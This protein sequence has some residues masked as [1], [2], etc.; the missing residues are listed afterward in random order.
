MSDIK[1]LVADLYSRGV[2]IN[3]YLR[4]NHPE[5]GEDAII[6]LSYDTQAGSYAE[7]LSQQKDAY[8]NYGKAIV[9]R[10]MPYLKDTNSIL[11]AGCGE[12][13]GSYQL[14]RA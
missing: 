13:T 4:R 11:D 10:L 7:E 8:H 9:D 5:L 6:R 1:K 2:N 12:L 14:I 3:Q